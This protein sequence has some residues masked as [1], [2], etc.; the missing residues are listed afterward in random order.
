MPN[1]TVQ[2]NWVCYY[3]DADADADTDADAD[4]DAHAHAHAHRAHRDYM[5]SEHKQ[6][7]ELLDLHLAL[8]MDLE[9][10]PGFAPG[11]LNAEMFVLKLITWAVMPDLHILRSSVDA[12]CHSHP[13]SHTEMATLKLITLTIMPVSR[14]L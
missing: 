14:S 7:I 13:F 10:A 2:I 12:C 9:L 5:C 3:T 11:P 8:L 1:I 6:K 4:E